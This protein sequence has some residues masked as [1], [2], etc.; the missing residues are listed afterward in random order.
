MSYKCFLG[1]L[2]VGI[3]LL[4]G[5]MNVGEITTEATKVDEI[6]E[7][8]LEPTSQ[9]TEKSE[10]EMTKS[11]KTLTAKIGEVMT[12]DNI[13]YRVNEVNTFFAV[14]SHYFGVK[15]DGIFYV[16]DIS[17][18]NLAKETQNLYTPRFRIIDSKERK[19]DEDTGAEF[20]HDNAISFGKQ[21]QP[22]LPIQGVIIFD[23][24]ESAE[25]LKLEI[26]GD[27]LSVEKILV[28]LE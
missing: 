26:S 4:T 21:L 15:A 3:F 17:V 2:I 19:Y 16:V 14:G 5:C 18:E 24:P 11:K 6:L 12:V 22:N 13:A 23:L 9:K 27:W 20:Y 10:P 7:P 25:G 28:G 8:T 1:I